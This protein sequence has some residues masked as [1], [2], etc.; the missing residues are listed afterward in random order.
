MDDAVQ[1][2]RRQPED[3]WNADGYVIMAGSLAELGQLDEAKA[4]VARGTANFPPL[5]TIEKF[6]LN[7]GWS[8]DAVPVMSNLMRKAGFPA[9]AGDGDLADIPE[10][11]RLPECV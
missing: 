7:R 1:T 3:N 6:A 5:L 8:A 10:P 4:L 9:C 11:V 2:Q